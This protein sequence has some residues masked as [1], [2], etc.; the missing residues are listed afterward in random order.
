MPETVHEPLTG[1]GAWIGPQIQDE[2]FWIYRL[3]D[4]LIAEIDAALAHA[5]AAAI[6]I[7]F[8]TDAFP[9]PRFAAELDRILEEL[10]T[11]HGFV[12]IRG[13][14]RERYSDEE[15]AIIY[16]GIGVHLGNPVSQNA[17]GHRLGHV[18]DEGKTYDDPTAR[19]YQ[20]RQRL[21]FHC[22]LLPV[23]VLG[24]FC[25][26]TAKRGG[27][28][29]IVSGLTI[30]NILREERPDLLEVSY[31]PFNLDWRDEEPEG[32]HPW[33]TIPMYSARQG[34]I[35]SR[36]CS[37]QYYESVTRY[38]QE[39]GLTD[40]QRQAL[41]KMQEIANRPE[42]RLSMDFREGDIQLL[43]NHMVLHS[44]EAYEDYEEEERKRHLL[45]MWIAVSEARRRP[46]SDA[47]AGRYRWVE[48]GGIPAK[49]DATASG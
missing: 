29:A 16:W 47:L 39:L 23:D 32:E 11:K 37:R 24:L 5:K 45:R 43:S 48:Q 25:L 12:L 6:E 9:L 19:G 4:G 28:S 34:S 40:L 18:R 35:S 41:D 14:P 22:D 44:R 31:Q 30:H 1:P 7:P 20:T 13:I 2:E 33:Y 3:D 15:C 46:L 27:T 38:G 21:D 17:R 36:F 8:P 10:Q 49:A 26:R 42:I